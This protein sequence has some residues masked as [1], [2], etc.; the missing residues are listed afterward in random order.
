MRLVQRPLLGRAGARCSGP[1]YCGH[2]VAAAPSHAACALCSLDNLRP[3][4]GSDWPPGG[5]RSTGKDGS[6]AKFHHRPA[7]ASQYQIQRCT[8]GP[9]PRDAACRGTGAVPQV[10]GQGWTAH[11]HSTRPALCRRLSCRRRLR[12]YCPSQLK[13]IRRSPVTPVAPIARCS[14]RWLRGLPPSAFSSPTVPVPFRLG[15]PP[16][17]C[18]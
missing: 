6:A 9:G 16:S 12:S 3:K 7:R 11:C 5:G 10:P 2:R 4:G 18:N 13:A 17:Y 15:W 14:G 8:A 1:R